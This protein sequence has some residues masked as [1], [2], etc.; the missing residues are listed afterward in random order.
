MNQEE[1]F[2]FLARMIEDNS[3]MLGRAGNVDPK[4]V[5]L[6]IESILAPDTNLG[7]TI[8]NVITQTVLAKA[9]TLTPSEKRLVTRYFVDDYETSHYLAWAN[10]QLAQKMDYTSD[11]HKSYLTTVLQ[12]TRRA[13]RDAHMARMLNPEENVLGPNLLYENVIDDIKEL[14]T[15]WCYAT[16]FPSNYKLVIPLQLQLCQAAQTGEH[17][18]AATY[19]DRI[20]AIVT[21]AHPIS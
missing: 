12:Y 4:K 14:L 6:T 2:E 18:Q 3:R 16:D 5:G 17:A 15:L 10:F 21:E 1:I 19:R 13:I 8:G 9:G 20:R 11:E 7:D